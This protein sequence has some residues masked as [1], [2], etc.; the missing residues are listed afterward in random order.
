[1]Q[2]T[3]TTRIV[4]ITNSMAVPILLHKPR[5][6][7]IHYTLCMFT[8]LAG[9]REQ[10]RVVVSLVAIVVPHELTASDNPQSVQGEQLG[11]PTA[12]VTS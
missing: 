11:A 4:A 7:F 1:M 12:R 8:N 6:Y 3:T 2:N 9:S 5:R 10:A